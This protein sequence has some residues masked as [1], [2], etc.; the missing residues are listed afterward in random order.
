MMGIVGF[1]TKKALREAVG[2][3]PRFVETSI[4]GPEYNG[5]GLYTIVGPDVY[6][7]K[8]FATVTV[9]DGKIA[10]VT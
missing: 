2:A 7:R 1:K 4:M 8:W 6:S 10:K 5:D 9:V 3:R